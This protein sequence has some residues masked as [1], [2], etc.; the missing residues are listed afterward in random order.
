MISKWVEFIDTFLMILQRKPLIFLHVWHHATVPVHM[1]IMLY[2]EWDSAI[3]GDLFN[4]FVHI[5]MYYYYTI[6]A[7]HRNVWWKELVT[8]LQLVQFVLCFVLLYLVYS[9]AER[10]SW[11]DRTSTA[12]A[13]VFTF[14]LSYLILF[15][16]FYISTYRKPRGS[17]S[18]KDANST[19]KKVE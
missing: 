3:F 1:Y 2:T 4:A 11:N 17:R 10:C 12:M 13:S 9:K 8:I 18:Q 15:I 16:Q 5:I 14:Y 7:V 19:V 6:R